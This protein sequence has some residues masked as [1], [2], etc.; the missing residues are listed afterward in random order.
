MKLYGAVERVHRDLAALGYPDG[1]PVPVEVLARLDQLHYHGTDAVDLAIEGT[2]ITGQSRVLDIGAGYGGPARW[3]AHQTGARVDAVEL[4]ADL[5]AAARD[6]TSR[7]G[8]SDHV[9][10]IQGDIL[11][12]PLATGAYDA[13]ISFLALYHIP[14]RQALFPNIFNALRSG[15]H[16]W[17]EDL[18]LL[19]TPTAAEKVDLDGMMAANTLPTREAY[20]SEL[21]AAGFQDIVFE[22]MTEDWAAFTAERLAAFQAIRPA[23]ER[24]HGGQVYDSIE[25][26]YTVIAKLLSGGNLGG[27]RYRAQKA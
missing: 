15:G 1:A 13:A 2:G 14:A 4:Q 25:S 11:Q 10:H 19:G 3:V 5:N 18:Y 26:F 24:T 16:L 21:S 17:A 12:T 7:C 23:Y 22:N 27:V 9:S 20:M 8:L 6:L